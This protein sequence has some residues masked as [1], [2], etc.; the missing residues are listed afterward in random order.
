MGSGV[1]EAA[2]AARTSS[3]SA[4]DAWSAGGSARNGA[5]ALAEP[6]LDPG[7][8]RGLVVGER[9]VLAVA[10]E[11]EPGVAGAEGARRR[12]VDRDSRAARMH[13]DELHVVLAA[14]TE[15]PARRVDHVTDADRPEINLRQHLV[16][17][18]HGT[19]AIAGIR[20]ATCR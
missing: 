14:R 6:G 15:P 17:C 16:H 19:G 5:G 1:R 12:V 4:V 8:V 3:L 11:Q 2:T 10:G 7:V 20:S 9:E 18:G 13:E